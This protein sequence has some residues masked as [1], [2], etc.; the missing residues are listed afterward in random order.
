[1]AQMF[2]FKTNRYEEQGPGFGMTPRPQAG[3]FQT[4]AVGDVS[5][6]PNAN[7]MGGSTFTETADNRG[8][9]DRLLGTGAKPGITQ[10]YNDN[11]YLDNRRNSING[12]YQ[13]YLGRDADPSGMNQYLNGKM[14]D[15]GIENSIIGSPEAVARRANPQATGQR[16]PIFGPMGM[17]IGYQG[18]DGQF[19][20]NS[21]MGEQ[22]AQPGGMTPAPAQG[23]TVQAYHPLTDL[24]AGMANPY[25]D[26][27][28]PFGQGYADTYANSIQSHYRGQGDA[29]AASAARQASMNGQLLTPA[30][31]EALRS[32]AQGQANSAEAQ[33]RFGF[34]QNEGGF[35]QNR[36]AGTADFNRFK[37]AGSASIEAANQMGALNYNILNNESKV[38]DVTAQYAPQVA[39][40]GITAG[41]DAHYSSVAG[42]RSTNSNT[43]LNDYIRTHMQDFQNAGM[44]EAVLSAL[45]GIMAT[46]TGGTKADGSA[47]TF[48]DKAAEWG[49][50]AL[51]WIV[52]NVPKIFSGNQ[53]SGGTSGIPTSLS[54]GSSGPFYGNQPFNANG[55]SGGGSGNAFGTQSTG[56]ASNDAYGYGPTPAPAKGMRTQSTPFA[57]QYGMSQPAQNTIQ[58]SDPHTQLAWDYVSGRA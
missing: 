30:A 46:K 32:G 37:T 39:A 28:N 51:G 19:T 44:T 15:G 23:M 24:Y 8:M 18:M 36:L 10:V 3:G 25:A 56:M 22:P 57:S 50:N 31:A 16:I 6:R 7:G 5:Y 33:A 9:F 40:Q 58:Y 55:S 34:K 27:K 38:S 49:G 12:F 52:E 45:P 17:I 21:G 1:M 11:S 54:S 47:E 43:D 42:T 26:A 20:P 48:W 41:N 2:N 13:K 53:G 35:E 4:K 29:A 14:N